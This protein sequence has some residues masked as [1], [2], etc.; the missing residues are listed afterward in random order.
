L[1]AWRSAAKRLLTEIGHKGGALLTVRVNLQKAAENLLTDFRS[2]RIARVTLETPA[3]FAQWLA[4]G[5][6]LDAERQLR[7]D[8]LAEQGLI[9]VKKPKTPA[10]KAEPKRPG[11][12]Q[13][14]APRSRRT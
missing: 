3:E 14:A 13:A 2:G 4:E 7:K 10:P 12:P 6:K 11:K 9:R 8:A 5:K 1:T